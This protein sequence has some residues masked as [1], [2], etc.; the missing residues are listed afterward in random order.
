MSLHLVTQLDEGYTLYC[1]HIGYTPEGTPIEKNLIDNAISFLGQIPD[2]VMKFLNVITFNIKSEYQKVDVNGNIVVG[3]K[4]VIPDSVRIVLNIF[5]I[6]M[7][8]ILAI[9]LV[10][11]LA[12]IIEAIGA[13]I[14]L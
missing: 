13:L 1:R 11:M 6:P 14:P 3:E 5:F 2:G 8:V 10:P 7:W 4:E 9:E 12:K